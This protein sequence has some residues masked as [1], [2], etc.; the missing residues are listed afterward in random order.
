MTSSASASCFVDDRLERRAKPEKL[1]LDLAGSLVAEV[2]TDGRL[3][4][5]H[6]ELAPVG[7]FGKLPGLRQAVRLLDRF[8]SLGQE[9]A[10]PV[11]HLGPR[12]NRCDGLGIR[13]DRVPLEHDRAKVE[14]LAVLDLDFSGQ[15]LAHLV[16]GVEDVATVGYSGE[17]ERPAPLADLGPGRGGDDDE[18]AHVGVDIA[19]QSDHPRLAGS[20]VPGLIRLH[21]LVERESRCY[22]VDVVSLAV[23]VGEPERLPHRCHLDPRLELEPMLIDQRDRGGTPGRRLGRPVE[24]LEGHDRRAHRGGAGVGHL[25]PAPHLAGLRRRRVQGQQADHHQGS[26][27]GAF[28][29]GRSS[30]KGRQALEAE[31]S[32]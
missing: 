27:H 9:D 25:D 29:R 28:H 12:S 26:R 5:G 14:R 3:H 2:A 30:S 4:V 20:E 11:R 17:L 24:R 18:P 31:I 1:A 10:D 13:R 23:L 22:D 7:I 6:L 32:C 15:R 8:T 19:D 16:P 21:T